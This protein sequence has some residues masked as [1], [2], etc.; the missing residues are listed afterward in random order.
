MGDRREGREK[1]EG[2]RSCKYEISKRKMKGTRKVRS[3]K[4]K[5]VNKFGGIKKM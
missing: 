4:W 5:Y 3:G 2:V 1:R